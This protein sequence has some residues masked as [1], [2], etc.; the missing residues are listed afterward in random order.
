M[1]D[2]AFHRAV[3][4]HVQLQGDIVASSSVPPYFA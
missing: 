4:H 3:Q 2:K 1:A